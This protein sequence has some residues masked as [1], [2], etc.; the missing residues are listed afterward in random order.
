MGAHNG[1]HEVVE[2]D[3]L[4]LIALGQPREKVVK[5]RQ[6]VDSKHRAEPPFASGV[7]AASE[8]SAAG[9]VNARVRPGRATGGAA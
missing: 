8:A 3:D 6:T 5:M 9:V 2:G 1:E 4:I 7:N